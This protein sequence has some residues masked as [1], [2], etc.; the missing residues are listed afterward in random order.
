MIASIAILHQT[1][2]FGDDQLKKL[3]ECL[4]LDGNEYDALLHHFPKKQHL[5]YDISIECS[6]VAK[7]VHAHGSCTK[8]ESPIAQ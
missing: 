6:D 5:R 1:R 4:L 8:H 3:L 7:I 2:F